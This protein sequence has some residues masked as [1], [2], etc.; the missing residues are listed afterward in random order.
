MKHT[1]CK[2]TLTPKNTPEKPELLRLFSN[3]EKRKKLLLDNEADPILK[4][5]LKPVLKHAKKEP[6][7]TNTNIKLTPNMKIESSNQAQFEPIGENDVLMAKIER[8]SHLLDTSKSPFQKDKLDLEKASSQ[9]V[10]YT[11]DLAPK[12]SDFGRQKRLEDLAFSSTLD[13][14]TSPIQVKHLNFELN[15][16][17]EKEIS[18][19]DAKFPE[20]LMLQNVVKSARPVSSSIDNPIV[21]DPNPAVKK[22]SVGTK[23]PQKK[24]K[25]V[26]EIRKE[27]ELRSIAPIT[28]YF[29]SERQNLHDESARNDEN[30]TKKNN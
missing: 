30:V 22:S 23:V 28:N 20:K 15:G 27:I 16:G 11:A 12:K 26:K 9:I 29:K 2:P 25:S 21:C 8:K 19:F 6:I 4:P 3:L 24:R 7:L 18:K 17:I 1:K 10:T 13:V 5:I 14:K